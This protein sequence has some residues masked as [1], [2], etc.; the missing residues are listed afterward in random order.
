M[1]K[2]QIL[3]K[4]VISEKTMSE[5]A[6]S[7]YSFCVN[8]DASKIDIKKTVENQFNVKVVN[9]K[10]IMM[11]GK[12]RSVRGRRTKIARSS[13][14]KAVVQLLPEQKIDLFEVTTG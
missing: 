12:T 10:T 7:R 3:I 14:K 9:I 13:W 8:S 6:K 2:G 5:A 11:K 1:I 4:P